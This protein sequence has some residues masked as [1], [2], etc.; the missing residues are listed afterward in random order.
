MSTLITS[1]DSP[2]KVTLFIYREIG[3]HHSFKRPSKLTNYRLLSSVL[4]YASFTSC[5]QDSLEMM[6]IACNNYKYREPLEFLF[7]RWHSTPMPYWRLI[8]SRD[9][10]KYLPPYTWS[11]DRYSSIKKMIYLLEDFKHPTTKQS[12]VIQF[13]ILIAYIFKYQ[14]IL[15]DFA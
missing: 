6:P 11:S 2:L 7:S 12:I 8:S 13:K 1:R 9:Y 4:S 5:A 10:P 15:D 3:L 14:T